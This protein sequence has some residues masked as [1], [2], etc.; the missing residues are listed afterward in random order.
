MID[1]ENFVNILDI[2]YTFL[3]YDSLFRINKIINHYSYLL[4]NILQHH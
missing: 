3:I 1:I 4:F 2:T